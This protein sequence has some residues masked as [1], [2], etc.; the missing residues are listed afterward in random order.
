MARGRGDRS[1]DGIWSSRTWSSADDLLDALRRRSQRTLHDRWQ[2]VRAT[3]LLA[4]Q[5][6]VAGSIA[7]YIAADVFHHP[8]PVFAPI[9]VIITLDLTVGQRYRRAIELVAGVALGV[10]FADLLIYVI[11]TGAWQIG[12]AVTLAVLVTV[13]F[14]GSPAVVAQA[15][16]SAIIIAA[17]VPPTKEG[18]YYER[19]LDALIGGVVALA[20][21]ALLFPVNPLTI[22]ARKTRPACDIIA[23]ALTETAAALSDRDAGRADAALSA[24]NRGAAALE[25][26]RETV[27]EGREAATIAPVRWRARGTLTQYVEAVEYL[28]RVL[29]N[30]R[31]LVRR[32]VT[33]ISDEEP[34]PE[35]LPKAVA[36]LGEAV[37]QLRAELTRGA[38][39]NRTSELAAQAVREAA[40][41]YRAGLG[42]SGSVLVAQIRAAA[43]DLLGAA[44]LTYPEANQLVRRAG[45][46]MGRP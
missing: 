3:A 25:E 26:L 38:P 1:D 31:V 33:L 11:G 27:P 45:G 18:I 40:D 29:G 12:L 37:H 41:A 17:V 5:A 24:I 23:G 15:A 7:W 28:E 10:A 4:L 6:G 16:S 42:F 2:R 21:M 19:F 39:L 13:F 9:A 14:G 43:T 34:V 8:D 22:V 35:Q 36:T 32:S 46:H 30:A 44:G 20:V